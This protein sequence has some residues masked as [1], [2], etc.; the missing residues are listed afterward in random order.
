MTPGRRR[1]WIEPRPTDWQ[2]LAVPLAIVL[3]AAAIRFATL[4]IQ[5]YEADETVTVSLLRLHFGPMLSAIPNSESTPPLYYVLAW[6]WTR[7]FGLGAVGLR[8]LSALFGTLL[9]AVLFVIADR[10]FSRRAAVVVALLAAVNPF[11]VWF[12][13]EARSYALLALL[14]AVS[15]GLFAQALRRPSRG[16]LAAWALISTA[17]LATH[18]FAVFPVGAEAL[19]LLFAAARSRLTI[20]A[21]AFLAACGALLTP[22]ALHQRSNAH[23]ATLI[24]SGGSLATRTAQIPKQFVLGYNGPAE[25]VLGVIG[26]ALVALGLLFWWLGSGPAQRA[27]QLPFAVVAAVSVA[28]PVLLAL[29]GEDFLIARNVIVAWAPAGL[30]LAAGVTALRFQPAGWVV[31]GALCVLFAAVL[32]AD[33]VDPAYQRDDWR[34]G[35]HAVGVAAV[36]RAL[37]VTGPA[38]TPGA[39]GGGPPVPLSLYLPSVE[40]VPAAGV[41]VDEVDY[42]ALAIRTRLKGLT[43][44]RSLTLPPSWHQIS[45]T[46]GPT[47]TAV[48]VRPNRPLLIRPTATAGLG[49]LPGQLLIVRPNTR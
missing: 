48:R 8:A 15:L 21:V 24:A 41:V 5:S 6:G 26:V 2:R 30:L 43:L 19:W 20:A 31:G 10:F 16:V 46:D 39:P 14:T 29:A 47:Y 13:Q 22:L 49:G 35:A 25:V 7:V 9:V 3:L 28:L 12:S 44:R 11:L 33:L 38:T 23:Y 27:T 36:A 17:A 1:G 40:A 37:I 34:D 18:Y 4:G 32:V 45:R 42:L